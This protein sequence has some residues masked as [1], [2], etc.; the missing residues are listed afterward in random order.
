MQLL[1]WTFAL[2]SHAN[3]YRFGSGYTLQFKVSNNAITELVEP[4]FQTVSADRSA[5]QRMLESV[6]TTR[7]KQFV[8]ENF[9]GAVLTEEHEVSAST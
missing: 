5:P 3:S 7:V 9:P 2:L 4:S 1:R 8:A 6:D